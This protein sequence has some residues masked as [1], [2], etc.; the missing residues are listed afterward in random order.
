MIHDN[1]RSN[2]VV[3]SSFNELLMDRVLEITNSTESE[4]KT[5][6]SFGHKPMEGIELQHDIKNYI[7]TF[8]NDKDLDDIAS[9]RSRETN[10][11]VDA[12]GLLDVNESLLFEKVFFRKLAYLWWSCGT[13]FVLGSSFMKIVD[14]RFCKGLQVLEW[15]ALAVPISKDKEF[16]EL[17]LLSNKRIR[18]KSIRKILLP[19]IYD[20]VFMTSCGW[21]VTVGEDFSSQLINPLSSE[22][23]NLLKVNTFDPEYFLRE[24]SEW[25]GGIRKLILLTNNNQSTLVL[26]L[27][28]VSWGWA[29][30]L[31]F[32]QPGDS[33]WTRVK[34][35]WGLMVPKDFYKRTIALVAYLIGV[36]DEERKRLLVLIRE[37]KR[38]KDTFKKKVFLVFAY[39]LKKRTW[40]KVKDLG[41]KALFVGVASFSIDQDTTRVIKGNS[42][43]FTD[44]SYFE[45]G[46]RG[47]GKCR[48]MGIY[49]L[50]DGTIDPLLQWSIT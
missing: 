32:C 45:H 26:P 8:E 12:Y 39:D 7:K 13:L 34:R 27:V 44:D 1:P 40:S 22:T 31:G 16:R 9:E 29:R 17:L 4:R 35:G 2:S 18:K 15:T 49:H 33:K 30:Q 48:D 25:Y 24:D 20:K 47:N 11:N 19:Q 46:L 41:T 6:F 50:S 10:Y 43:Y 36:D 28:F 3:A 5:H 23:I 38:V 37:G 42:I 21:L 14:I